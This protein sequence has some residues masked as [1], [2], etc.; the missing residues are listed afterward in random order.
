MANNK[1]KGLTVEIGGD[2]TNLGKALE[3]VNKKS[4]DLSSELGEINRL[5]KFDPGNTELLAQKQ[6]VLADAVTNTSEKLKT[7]KEAE[8][9]VQKQFERGEVSEE[10]VRALQREIIATEGRLNSYKKQAEGAGDETR[11]LGEAAEKSGDGFTVMKGAMANLVSSGIE[12][13]ISGI[14]NLLSSF[15]ELPEATREYRTEMGKLDTAF[16]QMGH[17]SEDA[18]SVYQSLQGVLGETDQAVEAANHI[19]KLVKAEG[20]LEVWTGICTGVYATFG[21]SLPIEG[22]TEAANETAKTGKITGALADALTWAGTNEEEFQK[23][24]DACKDEQERAYLITEQLVD[25]YWEA[26]EA[27]RETNAELIR[28]NEAN[29][30]W[31]ATMA[32]AGAALE[33][34][35]TDI[36]L[37]KT[38]LVEELLPGVTGVI[39]AF[40]GLVNGEEGSAAAVGEAIS[41]LL[42]QIVNMAVEML[43]SLI[44][45]AM[46]LITT[47]TTTLIT[48]LPQLIDTGILMI[49]SILDGLIIAIPQ[50]TQAIVDMIPKLV[51]SLVS[52]IPQLIDGAVQLLMAILDAIPLILPP[53]IL[54]IPQ[55][56]MSIIEALLVAIPQLIEGALQFLMAIIQA[57]PLLIQ[58]LLPQVPTIVNAIV[59]GLV[60][61]I[62]LLI[63]GAIELFFAILEAIP[64][65]CAALIASAPTIIKSLIDGLLSLRKSILKAGWDLI[66]GLVEGM[67]S[68]DYWGA[69]K[70]IGNGI[71]DG[72]K[73]LFDINSP[74]R[75]MA[76]LGEMLDEGLAVGIEDGAEAP[77]NALDKLSNDML[78]GVDGINGVSLERRMTHSFNTAASDSTGIG[79]KLDLIYKAILSGQVIM[80]D[81]KTLVGSTADRYDNE[82]GQRRVLAE[83]GAL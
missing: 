27:Y 70:K 41:G 36:K 26:G 78:D 23:K 3:S 57:I 64:D 72:F 81:G 47:L 80:L 13:M 79:N 35:Q 51:E 39:T 1:I 69:I 12:A 46:S 54:A 71:I 29:E 61:N 83:R 37:L 32:E 43:P 58:Q 9:Q 45:A 60:S 50:I 52:G 11:E 63:D 7:L 38:S 25:S 56:V 77:V 53:L 2:T 20:D 22:L 8:K 49:M 28:A 76:G 74:S 6:K 40:R 67:F 42:T 66:A 4:G 17:S 30:K 82:L 62:P 18:L 24:L 10:Q 21:A 44:T 5:L 16:T 14:S 33:P 65:I 68:F 31:A 75:V 59:N 34:L 73:S 19:A 15:A 55:I 48:M